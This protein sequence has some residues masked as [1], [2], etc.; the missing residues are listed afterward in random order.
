MNV[1]PAVRIEHLSLVPNGTSLTLSLDAGQ[2]LAVIGRAGA[3]KSRFL[4]QLS[5]KEKPASGAI[6][7]DPSRLLCDASVLPRKGKVNGLARGTSKHHDPARTTETLVA[8]GLWD[9]RNIGVEQLTPSQ[10]SAACMMPAL[11]NPPEIMLVD[12][13]L[14]WVDPVVQSNIWEQLQ[15]LR[16]SGVILVIA[17]HAQSVIERC[18]ALLVLREQNFIF[19]GSIEQLTERNQ[20]YH[21]TVETQRSQAIRNMIEPFCVQIEEI[22]NGL[23]LSTFEN[24]KVAQKLLVEGYGDVKYIVQQQPNLSD[25]LSSLY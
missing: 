18:D 4:R 7:A 12:M 23:R 1:A 11:S 10:S 6:F 13:L 5:G 8:A 2:A 17:T 25:I 9:Q 14:D 21:F 24:Q 15:K 16:Q 22:P 19:S 3:G 20:P